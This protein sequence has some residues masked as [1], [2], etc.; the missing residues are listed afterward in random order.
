MLSCSPTQAPKHDTSEDPAQLIAQLRAEMSVQ[1]TG[2]NDEL[3][4]LKSAYSVLSAA[5][6]ELS[7]KYEQLLN[8]APDFDNSE[9]AAQAG[10]HQDCR[11][12]TVVVLSGAAS[13]PAP[14]TMQQQ[15]QQQFDRLELMVLDAA[16]EQHSTQTQVHA[17]VGR[18]S[19]IKGR[20]GSGAADL[21][22]ELTEISSTVDALQQAGQHS[23]EA[24]EEVRDELTELNSRTSSVEEV[25]ECNSSAVR[26]LSD[27]VATIEEQTTRAAEAE[28]Q[29]VCQSKELHVEVVAIA[30]R[31][32]GI[33]EDVKG[34][35]SRVCTLQDELVGLDNKLFNME[36]VF[37]EP[38]D[39][40]VRQ[41]KP[42]AVLN[43]SSMGSL[44]V[45]KQC[46]DLDEAEPST[47]PSTTRTLHRKSRRRRSR[48]PAW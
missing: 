47:A 16:K 35:S 41:R 15:Q 6:H 8:T 24:F 39:A 11:E 14:G 7:T 1:I 45:V 42:L 13:E 32:W 46:D 27:R 25:A 33:Q 18:M 12:N 2:V 3:K 34:V 29:R 40:I 17:L 44:G 22:D 28:E 30:G 19:T 20:A 5:H 26:D 48:V 21:R 9:A 37:D 4:H 10:G 31:M 38:S 36:E 23:K 43:S